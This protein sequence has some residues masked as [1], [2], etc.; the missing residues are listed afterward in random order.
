MQVLKSTEFEEKMA[1]ALI[2]ITQFKKKSKAAID[3]N[4]LEDSRVCAEN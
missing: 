1:A 3:W 2:E 4:N